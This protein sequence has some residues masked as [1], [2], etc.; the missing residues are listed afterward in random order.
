MTHRA[1]NMRIFSLKMLANF[2]CH[3]PFIVVS[4]LK[5]VSVDYSLY[6]VCFFDPEATLIISRL[7]NELTVTIFYLN[8]PR[9]LPL[10]NSPYLIS[11][12]YFVLKSA[13]GC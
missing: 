7:P 9:L 10:K 4:S 6:N 12:H 8:N 2:Y 11:Q 3:Y 13:T 1:V 5:F